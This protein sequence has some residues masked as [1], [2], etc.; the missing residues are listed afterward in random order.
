MPVLCPGT[1]WPA[2]G[3]IA[4]SAQG[5]SA[6]GLL[7]RETVRYS[8]K[9]PRGTISDSKPGKEKRYKNHYQYIQQVNSS[10]AFLMNELL[11][12]PKRARLE[13][14]QPVTTGARPPIRV[15]LHVRQRAVQIHW[16]FS[17][18][19]D[20]I[21][22]THRFDSMA[23]SQTDFHIVIS[24]PPWVHNILFSVS[25][26]EMTYFP[27]K[28]VPRGQLVNCGVKSTTS[29][30]K[31]VLDVSATFLPSPK[32]MLEKQAQLMNTIG[33]SRLGGKEV[34]KTS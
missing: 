33:H 13:C 19:L 6:S 12:H 9:K 10:I 5:T 7:P 2:V 20:F 4:T 26:S 34:K 3:K 30:P 15:L 21:G 32:L 29:L 22:L 11:H 16:P 31:H 23:A 28:K 18:A 1:V 24:H 27:H 25:N 14:N 17:T 8:P